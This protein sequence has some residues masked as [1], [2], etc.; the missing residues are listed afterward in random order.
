MRGRSINHLYLLLTTVL[1][2]A[3]PEPVNDPLELARRLA[4][5]MKALSDENRLAILLAVAQ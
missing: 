5:V 2:G 4:P 1:T 3:Y